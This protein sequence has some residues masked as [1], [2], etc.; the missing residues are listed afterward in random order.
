MGKVAISHT[1]FSLQWC[2][3]FYSVDHLAVIISV[4]AEAMLRTLFGHG[5]DCPDIF[6]MH[7]SAVNDRYTYTPNCT[8][9]RP[10]RYRTEH[11]GSHRLPC[12]KPLSAL[13]FLDSERSAFAVGD[14]C[15]VKGDWS[16]ASASGLYATLLHIR[17]R[18]LAWSHLDPGVLLPVGHIAVLAAGEG[19]SPASLVSPLLLANG[20]HCPYLVVGR[21]KRF[22][23]ICPDL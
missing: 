6:Y 5:I 3:C 23:N 13:A 8:H 17:I 18:V 1:A 14:G 21:K 20:V 11:C 15:N 10:V 9:T 22:R 2:Y 12:L 16:E 19:I 4:D 7:A